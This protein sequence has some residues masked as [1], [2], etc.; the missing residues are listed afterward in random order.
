MG[1]LQVGEQMP[2]FKFVTPFETGRS[3]DETVKA[4]PK[5]AVLFLRYY[6]CTLC[7]YDIHQMAV[8]YD[9]ISAGGGQILVVLQSE[10]ET[11]SG[12]MKKDDLPFDIICDPDQVLYKEFDIQP[13]S[14]MASMVD[15]KAMLK[16]ARVT[17][18]GLKHGK[19]EGNEQQLPAAFVM[20][21][22]RRLSYVRYAKTIADMPNVDELVQ[23]LA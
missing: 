9:R 15:A 10:P 5:T 3:L 13:A 18:S 20:D 4:A 16:L 19:Y 7:Q 17:A 1:K 8:N 23:L 14:S 11:I 21:S 12:Q 2:D 22:Q 6:G